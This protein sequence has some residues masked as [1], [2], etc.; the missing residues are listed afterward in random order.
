[1]KKLEDDLNQK[2]DGYERILSKQ[3]YL[4]GDTISLA[5]L[6]VRVRSK[7]ACS[8]SFRIKAH[9]TWTIYVTL[10]YGQLVEARPNVYKWWKSI[11]GR[12]SVARVI[13]EQVVD[14]FIDTLRAR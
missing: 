10:G 4:A 9:S 8:H 3:D 1:M 6:F 11:S 12:K 5:D 14:A 13:E 7:R 2:L